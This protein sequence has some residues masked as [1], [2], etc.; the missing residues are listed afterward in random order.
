VLPPP[1]LLLLLQ[2]LH[3]W[4]THERRAILSWCKAAMVFGASAHCCCCCPPAV[5]CRGMKS[6]MHPGLVA[7]GCCKIVQQK[8]SW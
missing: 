2:T 4:H 3:D 5:G 1:L 6:W 7:W 8:F